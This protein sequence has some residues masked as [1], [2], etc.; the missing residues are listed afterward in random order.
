MT[1]SIKDENE[2]RLTEET[3]TGYISAI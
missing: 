2:T 3:I 1:H